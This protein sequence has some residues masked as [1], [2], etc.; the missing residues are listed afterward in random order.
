MNVTIVKSY[1]DPNKFREGFNGKH[2]RKTPIATEA[3]LFEEN[4]SPYILNVEI[5]FFNVVSGIFITQNDGFCMHAF[6][7]FFFLHLH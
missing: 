7:L 6:C 3:N 4:D 5:V 2:S 1:F